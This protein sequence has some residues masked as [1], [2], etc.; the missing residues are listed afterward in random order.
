MEKKTFAAEFRSRIINIRERASAC[1]SS[2]TALCKNNGI[3]RAT[4]DRWLANTPKTVRLIDEL[5]AELQK[6]EQAYAEK[7]QKK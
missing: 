6:A 1:G 5:E 4:P 3:A 2:L 7:Q